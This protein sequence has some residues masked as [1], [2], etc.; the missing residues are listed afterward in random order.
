MELVTSS[1]SQQSTKLGMLVVARSVQEKKTEHQ[2]KRIKS[3]EERIKAFFTCSLQK[4]N[5]T[6]LPQISL[7][8]FNNGSFCCELL[9]FVD[10]SREEEDPGNEDQS[11][12][13]PFSPGH[14]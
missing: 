4:L 8:I 9:S 5:G 7:I 2:W 12:T 3:R 1:R 14:T 11:L 13:Q 10:F 6:G